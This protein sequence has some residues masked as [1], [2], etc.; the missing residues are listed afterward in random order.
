MSMNSQ[1]R[2]TLTVSAEFTKNSERQLKVLN[3]HFFK[4]R[5]NVVYLFILCITKNYYQRLFHIGSWIKQLKRKKYIYIMYNR[6]Y[7]KREEEKKNQI[8]NSYICF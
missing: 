5:D 3:N 1:P 6:S 8:I 2:S 4:E 7:I